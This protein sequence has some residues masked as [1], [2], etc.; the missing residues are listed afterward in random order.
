MFLY[1]LTTIRDLT[2]TI[3][4][5]YHPN[6]PMVS[7]GMKG[8]NTANRCCTQQGS[9]NNGFVVTTKSLAELVHE[10][11]KVSFPQENSFHTMVMTSGDAKVL[12]ACRSPESRLKWTFTWAP[13][14]GPQNCSG[15]AGERDGFWRYTNP[16]RPVAMSPVFRLAVLKNTTKAVSDPPKLNHNII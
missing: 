13:A 14:K 16:E 7:L 12:T 11:K 8:S 15:S 9:H 6:V 5:Y 2:V 1:T 10:H 3:H 4:F